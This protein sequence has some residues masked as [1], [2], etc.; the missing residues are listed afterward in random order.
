MSGGAAASD[1]TAKRPGIDPRLYQ[2]G[3]LSGL[4][5]YGLATLGLDVS[6]A[7]AALLLAA[8]L[9]AQFA[10]TKIWR[11]PAFEPRSAIISGLSL[12]L[13][14]RCGSPALAVLAAAAAVSSKF[15]LR[16]RGKHVFNP[17]NFAI[18][19]SIL[20]T[21]EVWVSPAQW[22]N[23]AFFGFLLACAGGIVVQRAARADVTAAF[24]ALYLAL[25]LG[26]SLWLGEP[27]AIPLHR[28]QSGS[29]LIFAFFMI[30]DPRT[31]PD[32]RAGRVLFG[33]LVAAGAAFV[34]F[35]LFRT[36]GPLWS[37]AA[38][39]PLVPA[40][41]WLLPGPRHGWPRAIPLPPS[42]SKGARHETPLD[43]PGRLFPALRRGAPGAP[44]LRLLRGSGRRETL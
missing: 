19:A 14:L 11:L 28:L 42:V 6:P 40:I 41:D 2:I 33:A 18:V 44:V 17:T 9:G 43:S 12:G 5:A 38:L 37:L 7:R 26:R 16:W 20:A 1:D 4:L 29:L 31:T 10:C 15:L 3:A 36:N 30:S 39:S 32:A 34:Q 27:L 35:R 13:L 21:R 8:A 24:L 23:G 25:V 22:G